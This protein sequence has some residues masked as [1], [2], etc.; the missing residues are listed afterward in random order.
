MKISVVTVVYNCVNTIKE[1]IESVLSQTY[2]DI[3]Y[4]VI[5]GG[6][7]DGTLD[8]VKSYSDKIDF[9]ISEKDNGIYDAMNKGIRFSS[10]QYLF[11][12]NSGDLFYDEN[13][14]SKVF[15]DLGNENLLI[16]GN[17]KLVPSN[18]IQN[19][20]NWHLDVRKKIIH[21]SIFMPTSFCKEVPFNIA[22]KIMAD[23]KN[24]R[25]FIK[26]YP[27][28]V[29]YLDFPIC[30]YDTSGVS[31]APLYTYWKEHFFSINNYSFV[32]KAKL[33]IHLLPRTLISYIIK[34]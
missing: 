21:Q 8:I 32:D 27:H 16:Y 9:I 5:D 28:Y 15:K 1:T 10:G 25:T 34:K 2:R 33:L 24:V 6:S 11:F 18:L 20:K 13:T 7:E 31:S 30:I 14:L 19:Q 23:Y 26:S 29:V 22:Y 4:L 17:A 12:L 3:E